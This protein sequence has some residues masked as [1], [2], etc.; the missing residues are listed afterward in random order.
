MGNS[1]TP[2]SEVLPKT[3]GL[4]G[5]GTIALPVGSSGIPSFISDLYSNRGISTLIEVKQ[6]CGQM[7]LLVV[8]MVGFCLENYYKLRELIKMMPSF[9]AAME[10]SPFEF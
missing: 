1:V 3:S 4:G 8:L 9:L 7:P 6:L 5:S 2:D 10:I